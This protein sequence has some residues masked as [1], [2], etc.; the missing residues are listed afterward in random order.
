[1][2]ELEFHI[3]VALPETAQAGREP[4]EREVGPERDGQRCGLDLVADLFERLA[5]PGQGVAGRRDEAPARRGED[6]LAAVA[7]EQA[8]PELVLEPADLVTYG[9]GAD[10]KLFGSTRNFM[11]RAAASKLRIAV[12]GRRDGVMASLLDEFISTIDE[13]LA[14]VMRPVCI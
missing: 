12:N 14:F 13:K 11:Y 6:E 2:V 7:V 10:G 3:R 5:E 9:G 4:L 1:M 8:N